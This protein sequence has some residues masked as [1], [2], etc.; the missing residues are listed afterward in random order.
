MAWLI[1]E[2][3]AVA[4]ATRLPVTPPDFA[5]RVHGLLGAVGSTST[6]LAQTLDRAEAL[7]VDTRRA[8]G[9]A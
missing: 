9:T 8:C 6:Q 5:D 7:I 4:S 3:G 1:N 2:K